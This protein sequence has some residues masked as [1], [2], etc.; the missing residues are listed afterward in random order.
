MTKQKLNSLAKKLSL[1]HPN[2][3]KSFYGAH[4]PLPFFKIQ[5]NFFIIFK[6]FV[7][8][9]KSVTKIIPPKIEVQMQVASS[10]RMMLGQIKTYPKSCEKR[11]VAAVD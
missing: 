4:W 6:T 1:T 11:T 9:H 3:F 2:I 8:I 5:A 10:L 7:D